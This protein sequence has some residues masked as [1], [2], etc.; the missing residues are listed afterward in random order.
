MAWISNCSDR[1]GFQCLR[2]LKGGATPSLQVVDAGHHF[3]AAS[4]CHGF[5][6]SP[7]V[8]LS[9]TFEGQVSGGLLSYGRSD[10]LSAFAVKRSSSLIGSNQLGRMQAYVFCRTKARNIPN[11]TITAPEVRVMKRA[12]A[13]GAAPALSNLPATSTAAAST[14]VLST[15]QILP[16]NAI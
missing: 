7:V 5:R 4:D 1:R 3:D 10:R 15:T 9:G 14:N 13:A 11:T 2:G 12:R 6:N 16:S 8:A